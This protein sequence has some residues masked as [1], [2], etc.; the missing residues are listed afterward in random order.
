MDCAIMYAD[1]PPLL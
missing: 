1:A